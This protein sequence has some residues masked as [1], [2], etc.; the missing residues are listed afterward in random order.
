MNSYS[1]TGS[2]T[3]Y[4][5]FNNNC[6][7]L[8][9]AVPSGGS[10]TMVTLDQS[11]T[12]TSGVTVYLDTAGSPMTYR[13]GE[14]SGVTL[15][16]GFG[17]TGD[18]VFDAVPV[19][20]SQA[21]AEVILDPSFQVVYS[22]NPVIINPATVVT[23]TSNLNFAGGS[24]IQ[25]S[26]TYY[27]NAYSP[28]LK[29]GE[30]VSIDNPVQ[31]I[32]AGTIDTNGQTGLFLQEVSG[33]GDLTVTGSGTLKLSASAGVSLTGAM[34]IDPATTVEVDQGSIT[35]PG[36]WQVDGS[37]AL[38]SDSASPEIHA[39]SG[40]GSVVLGSKTLTVD[41]AGTNFAGSI[42]GA[43]GLTI[44]GGT[45]TLS[46]SN[47][48]GGTTTINGGAT[49]A[50]TGGGSIASSSSVSDSG[51]LDISSTSG[52]AT[53]KSLSGGGAVQLGSKTLTL[54]QPSQTFSGNIQ[55]SGNLH[56]ASGDETLS[57]GNFYT[58]LTTIDSGAALTLSAGGTLAVHS[59]MLDNGTLRFNNSS[60]TMAVAV[61]GSGGV[62]VAAGIATLTA[63]SNY[64]GPTSIAA[65]ST[66]FL[67]GAGSIANSAVNDSGLLDIAGTDTG[68]SIGSLA[69]TGNVNLG[70]QTLSIQH[71]A[72]TLSGVISGSGGLSIA[73]GTETLTGNNRYTGLTTIGSGAT[74][75]LSGSGS[76][77]VA[78]NLLDNGTLAFENASRSW[79]AV[80]SGSGGV[81]VSGGSAA[82]TAANVYTGATTISSG[83]T[84]NL[85]GSGSIVSSAVTDNGTLELSGS[86]AGSSVLSLAGS[87]SVNLGSQS[88]RVGQAAGTL[89]GAIA[90]SGGLEIAGGTQTLSASNTYSGT[91]HI[92]SGATLALSGT[93]SLGSSPVLDDGT[94]DISGTTAGATVASLAGAGGVSLGAQTLS[95]S[96]GGGNTLGGVITGSGGLS[97]LAGTQILTASN[98]YSGTTTIG[99]GATLALAGT[100]SIGS[101]PVADNGTLD[102]SATTSGA[103]VGSIAGAGGVSLGAQTLSITHA[104]GT[105][106][107]VISGSG[108]LTIAG[109]TE[110]L[111]GNSQ[112]TGLTTIDSGATLA[113]SG[114]GSFAVAS[115]LLDNGT[116][117]F[118]NADRT[119]SAVISG[120]GGV[121]VDGGSATL[122]AANVY[123]GATTITSGSSLNLIGSG[124]IVASAVSD[125]G[126][127]DISGAA[128]SASVAAIAGSGSVLLGGNS[129]TVTQASGELS[130]AI[131]GAGGLEIAGGHQT[132]SGAN[133]FGGTTTIDSGATLTLSGSA[134]LLSTP[135]V[136]N[137]LL[138]FA[139]A[140]QTYSGT[141]TGHGGVQVSAGRASLSGPS[142]YDGVTS[143][144]NG[145]TLLLTDSAAIARSLV[146]DNGTLDVSGSTSGSTVA[147]L[148]GVGQVQLGAQTLK[149][150]AA[151]SDFGGTIGGSG[152]LE[153]AGGTQT[154]SGAANN[155]TGVTHIDG[156]ATLALAGSGS[157]GPSPVLDDG[158]LNISG[159]TAGATVVSLAG[160]GGVS[161]GAQTLSLSNASGTLGGVIAG[162]GGLSVLG[163]TQTLSGTNSYSGSSSIASGATLALA[164]TGSLSASP[165][166][167]NGTLDISG[168]SA[169][170]SI[171]SIAGSGG[172]TLGAQTLTITQ[173]AGTL[174]GRIAGSGGLTIAA[175]I[176]T[177]TG[178]SDYTGLSTI[179]SGAT[180]ALS[181]TGA[182]V[183]Q[184]R[185]LDNGTLAFENTN[186]TWGAAISGSG[187]VRVGGGS[188]SL[189]GRN[190]YTGATAISSGSTLYLA[191]T[192]SAA[193]SAV[194]ADGL[195]DI[196]GAAAG[197][198][199]AGLAGAGQVQLGAQTL[200]LAA[201]SSSFGGMISGSGSLEV[202]GGTQTLS[203]G[204][205]RYTGITHIDSGATLALAG[206]GSPGPSPVLDDGTLDISATTSGATVASLA[207]A[208]GVSLGAQTLSVSNASGTLGGVIAG[209]GGL[210][211][212]GGTQIL[213]GTNTYSGTTSIS[214][215][216][217]LALAGTG[218]IGASPVVDAGTL[219]ISGSRSGASVASIAGAGGVSLGNRTL[220]V[221]Q[222]SG[223]LSGA[224]QGSGGLSIA[225]GTE[226]L[227]G[228]NGY[229]GTTTVAGGATLVV[230][231]A[232][233]L[234]ATPVLADGT[235][236]VSAS[237]V[238]LN[239]PTLSGGGQLH[240][241]ANQLNLSNASGVFS[242]SI[243]GSA[244]LQLLAGQ[245][246]LSGNNGYTGDTVVQGGD[247]T[248]GY[249]GSLASRL[250]VQPAGSV[251]IAGQATV[252]R[253]LN[254]SGLLDV[255]ESAAGPATLLVR[256]SYTQAANAT[257]SV[258]LSPTSHASLLVQG[259]Q[260]NLDGRLLIVA[261]P[262]KY[263]RQSY[264]LVDA[265]AST[266]L[267]GQFS[268]WAVQGLSTADY[269]FQL[270]YVADPQVVFSLV[271]LHPFSGGAQNP[272]ESQIGKVLD[273]QVAT[274]DSALLDRLNLLFSQDSVARALQAMDGE[275]YSE[276][277]GWLLQGTSR[278][279]SA[280][281]ER[282]GM[283]ELGTLPRG[284]QAFA[285]IT[286]SRGQL[287]GDG[288][289]LGL[290]QNASGLTIGN[291][292]QLGAWT[293]G[294]AL[295][296]LDL[297]ATRHVIGDGATTQLYRG[298]LF[299]G[300]DL[301]ALRLGTVLGY[302][303]GRVHYGSSE[304]DA[305]VWT[306]QSRLDRPIGLRN[307]DLLTPL[308]GLD[309]Q[310][311]RLAAARESDPLL[312]LVVP[313][314]STHT[315]STLAGLRLD[316]AWARGG[317]HGTVDASLGMR[318]WL[319]RPPA[320][321]V[322]GF[323]GIPGAQFSN[324]GVSPPR[325]ALE[326][327]M[328]MHAELRRTL[329]AEV[330]YRGSYGRQYRSND[331]S[332]R[333]AWKF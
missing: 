44:A 163:G 119:W 66:L 36:L 108:G 217:T 106:S 128:G 241:G 91:T 254:N 13:L 20:G 168:T 195:L 196:S 262:G 139:T 281:F 99:A 187:G 101:S 38:G 209:S 71:A 132:L 199:V 19:S 100:G 69:G 318:H 218:S 48:Y 223:T 287:L 42:Q 83:S 39:L 75:A 278:E 109:G 17:A 206:S 147:G 10:S 167:D 8:S 130:G 70:S 190:V 30:P 283:G 170:T 260:L 325:N 227:T 140:G 212:L 228:G 124:S 116:L 131:S 160:A 95:L 286:A 203:G 92:D 323:T 242:G 200:T 279:W 299:A 330:S 243:D 157:T 59:S 118:E 149:L 198:T 93:G 141:I 179:D 178:F 113:L 61:S 51:T 60:S 290:D 249:G 291:Q 6:V 144:D 11:Y 73:S 1:G 292:R 276:T 233:S 102:I 303:G 244:G 158:M 321:L 155:Y 77:A 176:E 183:P 271:A 311:L 313:Q 162:S 332:L 305:R 317:M 81:L 43:G 68:T 49:L 261:S 89:A 191:G 214:A 151:S 32:G 136:N 215:G 125:D 220:T 280:L 86:F 133:S 9:T 258:G 302:S 2:G 96:N 67:A 236:D 90:G 225:G 97:L 174:A 251:S 146:D 3:L 189:T 256:G 181:G 12:L 33:S 169:G 229:T 297:G 274:A 289:A 216:A 322:L 171:G 304:R 246:T 213:T 208:G 293:V 219:D 247:L 127:F 120:S 296:T 34:I 185:L 153:V 319:R 328:A 87:G 25:L 88:L 40:S 184:S 143:I 161:L 129:L 52:G 230:A 295:G 84:L 309:L 159:T 55:G 166:A 15:T 85:S 257:L 47:G 245:Q 135:V 165:V 45:Q 270:Q 307:G 222:A 62:T 182:S 41:S 312:G 306:W 65:G 333:L 16:Y 64:T 53:I 238:P 142:D 284:E 78:S 269:G 14:G 226:T 175:G 308:L 117:A 315:L 329:D 197:T 148:S 21:Y 114:T 123:T 4:N 35:S 31:V 204:S 300:R 282:L 7:E 224:I 186:S 164:G 285:S 156:G 201:A 326:A 79:G 264:V 57:G 105:L 74:L 221:T 202:A 24:T 331:L 115:N 194:T 103:S 27:S 266:T 98:S 22:A 173:A 152:G 301:G 277:P 172:V 50:L 320:M 134:T 211:V 267:N 126:S 327:G 275:L 310:Q 180:L 110:T 237:A 265:P 248:L 253:D 56:I 150:A 154:L 324:W 235:L 37:F 46:G 255:S 121:K 231:G 54:S 80:I 63:V 294:A 250:L 263:L 26:H 18:M 111:S 288:N 5:A 72:G 112:Y 76:F 232:G 104:A 210:S 239:I 188:V 234:G 177:L 316:H 82:L 252:S 28:T 205:N 122:G 240:L 145:A 58:G 94:L 314:Q 259:A 298:G 272:N 268:S 137:G 207:G 29:F 107:G 193:N 23:A 192:G 273:G 138:D